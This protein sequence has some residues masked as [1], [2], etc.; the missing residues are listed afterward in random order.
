[1]DKLIRSIYFEAGYRV[2]VIAI[3]ALIAFQQIAERRSIEG[4]SFSYNAPAVQ[5]V[6]VI[7]SEP[8]PVDAYISVKTRTINGL[9]F[10]EPIP[11][12]IK[13]NTFP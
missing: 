8:L 2:C 6:E 7:N 10:Q 4:I 12:E 13:N 5:R 9:S 11:V 1:M 3:L